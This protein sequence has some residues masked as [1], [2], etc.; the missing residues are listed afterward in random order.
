M[1]VIRRIPLLLISALLLYGPTYVVCC[2]PIQPCKPLVCPVNPCDPPVIEVDPIVITTPRGRLDSNFGNQGAVLS[3][4]PQGEPSRINGIA[5]QGINQTER[6]VVAGESHRDFVTARYRLNGELDKEFNNSGYIYGRGILANALVVYPLNSRVPDR[7]VAVGLIERFDETRIAVVAYERNG[8]KVMT[9]AYRDEIIHNLTFGF[10][11]ADNSRATS[12]ALAPELPRTSGLDVIIGGYCDL[13]SSPIRKSVLVRLHE[14]GEISHPNGEMKNWGYTATQGLNKAFETV[15]ITSHQING[16]TF[17]SVDL[18]GLGNVIAVGQLTTSSGIKKAFI[19]RFK[20]NNGMLDTSFG[21]GTGHNRTGYTIL[22]WDGNDE[23]ANAVVL[24]AIPN[25][26]GIAIKVV[27]TTSVDV[28]GNSIG[29][30]QIIN[31]VNGEPLLFIRIPFPTGM[32]STA[33]T[34]IVTQKSVA[35]LDT[36]R[37]YAAGTAINNDKKENFLLTRFTQFGILDTSFGTNGSII[38]TLDTGNLV[39]NGLMQQTNG[40]LVIAG[41]NQNFSLSG[42]PISFAMARIK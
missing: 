20:N 12:V 42:D 9:H 41:Y 3:F 22:N 5:R 32:Q 6:I 40:E 31:I 1:L 30:Q 26:H 14:N 35:G 4:V 24:S 28:D 39:G 33:F 8:T 25:T 7:I 19:A 36:G 11:L 10:T 37:T 13:F 15:G 17:N 34:S 18:G 29:V 16:V 23:S 2:Y 21:E 27:G 38:A